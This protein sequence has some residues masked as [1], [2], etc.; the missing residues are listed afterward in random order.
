[1]EKIFDIAK[2][3][4]QKWGVIAQGIDGNFEEIE[5][6]IPSK[7]IIKR[8]YTEK[9]EGGYYDQM[10]DNFVEKTNF[11]VY[12]VDVED[13]RGKQVSFQLYTQ[14]SIIN[15]FT[16]LKSDGSVTDYKDSK[17]P[18]SLYPCTIENYICTLE[19]PQDAKMLWFFPKLAD[20]QTYITYES[21]NID[22]SFFVDELALQ[23]NQLPSVDDVENIKNVSIAN[24]NCILK[25]IEFN[26]KKL[27]AFGDS[28]T[29]GTC[30]PNFRYAGDNKYIQKFCSYVE[31]TLSN[32]AVSGS[33]LTNDSSTSICQKVI[34]NANSDFDIIWIA[35]GT[36]DFNA[37]YPVGVFGDTDA[38]SS[39]YGALHTICEHL[40]T[41]CPNA[42]VIF[43]TP[44]PYT[45]DRYNKGL[46][47]NVEKLDEYRKAI[48]EVATQY[49][50]NVV[51]GKSL[52]MPS[53]VGG[54]NDIMCDPSDGCHPTIE[55]HK[56]YA[57]SL[58]GVLC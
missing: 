47:L 3:S 41:N 32:F 1:M 38:A 39:F 29:Y 44:I 8:E 48:F 7:K 27:A 53:A 35:G 49:E 9:K 42:V 17:I 5:K 18:N 11:N 14:D 57:R 55:G 58:C 24:V 31:A 16:I 13:L 12:G 36:N 23:I 21:G 30:S 10:T 19:I 22:S 54:W 2:D 52:G 25:P 26:N 33:K 43:V 28:I 6:K 34:D 46:E 45:T 4:E 50:Y 37:K 20:P 51:S 15:G 56:L 40:K